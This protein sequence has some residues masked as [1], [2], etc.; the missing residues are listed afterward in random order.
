MFSKAKTYA[1]GDQV[2]D[3][4]GELWQC[5]DNKMPTGLEPSMDTEKWRPVLSF[6]ARADA[7]LTT[8]SA[9][10]P[11][12]VPCAYCLTTTQAPHQCSNCG[13]PK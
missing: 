12:I 5:I 9:L 10:K 13:A 1:I 7:F 8:L 4:D 6:S 2:C 3:R 11:A